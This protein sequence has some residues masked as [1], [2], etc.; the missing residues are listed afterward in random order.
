[1]VQ[2]AVYEVLEAI[3]EHDFLECYYGFRPGRS[4]HDVGHILDQIVQRG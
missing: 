2:D 4:A 3:Y 1:M